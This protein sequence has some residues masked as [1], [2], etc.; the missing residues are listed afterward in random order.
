MIFDVV[1]CLALFIAA[2]LSRFMVARNSK[3]DFDFYGHMYFVKALSLTGKPFSAIHPQSIMCDGHRLPLLW[4]F[5]LKPFPMHW[6]LRYGKGLNV[7]LDSLFAV[8][9]FIYGLW[10]D[11]SSVVSLTASVTYILTPMFFSALSWGP[12]VA[13]LTPRLFSEVF[14]NLFFMTLLLPN[15]GSVVKIVPSTIF[16]FFV[17][18]SS[19]FGLQAL[20]FI[21]PIIC[22]LTR[23]ALPLVALCSGFGVTL[24]LSGGQYID[25]AKEQLHHLYWYFINNRARKTEV[26]QRNSFKRLFEKERETTLKRHILNIC[27]KCLV[28]NSFTAVLL[29]MPILVVVLCHYAV[30]YGRSDIPQYL[31]PPFWS[32]LIVYLLVNVP[33]LLFLGEAERYLNHVAFFVV[34]VFAYVF[35]ADLQVLVGI[36][37]YGLIFWS[38]EVLFLPKIRLVGNAR[39]NHREEADAEIIEW[40]NKVMCKLKI[41]CYPYHAVGVYKIM[42]LTHHIVYFPHFALKNQKNTEEFS[43]FD[44]GYPFI[45]LQLL[46]D[47][48]KEFDVDFVIIDKKRFIANGLQ[49]WNPSNQ[50]EALDLGRDYYHVYIRKDVVE[51]FPSVKMNEITSPL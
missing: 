39:S 20:L 46:D 34:T 28:T 40:L 43:K 44:A 26:S 5:M 38:I 35:H 30:N 48:A 27:M 21:T 41:L 47:M 16:G 14:T 17:I 2:F 18:A 22:I 32:A 13:N 50:W 49:D 15:T 25:I 9:I 33:C 3:N 4:H 31:T 42:L 12:R 45:K 7:A 10:Y 36:F 1:I 19:K 8:L 24:L 37:A 29:K 6:L 51:N 11:L 23:D